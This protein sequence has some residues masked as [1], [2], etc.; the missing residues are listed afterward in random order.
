MSGFEVAGIVLGSIPIVVSALQCYMSGLGTLQNFRSYKRI[1]KS[2]IL[3]L[4]TEHVNLQNICEKLLTG[5]APQTRIEEMIRDPFGH[6]WREEE[7]FNKLRLRLWSS[8]QVFD[9]RVQDM[10]E[11]I[12]EIMEKLNI[13]TDGKTDW[14][15]SS[16]IK[17]QFK[18]A[19]FILQKSNHEEALTRIRDGVSALQ[20]LAV[21]NTDLE[22]QRKSRS[23][24]RLNKLVNGMLSGIYHALRSTMTC[25]C[26]G[27]HDVGLRLTPPSRTVIPE[28]DDEDIIKELQ[29]RLAIS[30]LTASQTEASKHWNEILLKSKEGPNASTVSFTAQSTSASRKTVGFAVPSTTSSTNSQ[31]SQTVIIESALSNLTLNTLRTISE[32]V[33]SKHISNLCE[34]MQ[35]MGKR[36]QGEKCGH[37]QHCYMT[38]TQKYD[39]YTLECLG[40]CDEWS[41]VPLKQVLQDPALL[42]GDKLRLAW[43]IACGVLQMQGTPWVADI[44]RSEDLFIA[45]KG[46]IHQF[47][48]VFVLRHFPEYPR[49]NA[50]VS[51]TNPFMLYLGILLIELI[52]GHSI[53]T[54]DSPQT[55]T[56]EPGLPRHILDYE[57]A[58]KLLGRVMMTGGSGYYNAVERC[59]RSDMQIDSPVY[60]NH[61]FIDPIDALVE[62]S[63]PGYH[64]MRTGLRRYVLN[65][66]ATSEYN[67]GKTWIFTDA[68]EASTAGET[69]AKGYEA[70]ARKRGV[71]FLS[72][73]LECEIEENIRRAINPARS[74]NVG[75]KLTDETILRPV[76]EKETIYRFGNENELVLD[77]TKLS[78]EEAA[79]RIEEHV[80]R[81]AACP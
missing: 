12:E 47:Q 40:S 11:A 19:T 72:I 13:G 1:L 48:H 33:C 35:T 76:L 5:I 69:G 74:R 57:A 36:K 63:S 65:E 27:L 51:P 81:L 14:T 53:T 45:E 52:L 2:L 29:F 9:D 16:S 3:T 79:L 22:S 32:P 43:M 62:R 46:G 77:V 59:L 28:D 54:L 6:L 75:A 37:I 30:Y 49:V 24:G 38:Q 21:L 73:V 78:A 20:R 10:R 44:P 15:D 55:Q 66:I 71:S 56:L 50:S 34:A 60:H 42:Y 18:R 25:K 70:A 58:N 64:E 23:Q 8:L 7:I 26:S 17:K 68:R 61:L 31:Q 67:K 41:L 80:D 4:K 39:V